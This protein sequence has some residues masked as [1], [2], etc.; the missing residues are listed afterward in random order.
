MSEPQ[1]CPVCK[2][3]A[4]IQSGGDGGSSKVICPRCGKFSI[5]WQ[6]R[7]PAE[8]FS[9]SQTANLSGWIREHQGCAIAVPDMAHLTSLPTP[10]VGEKAERLMLHLA[11]NNSKPGGYI[12]ISDRSAELLGICWC[13]DQEEFLFILLKYLVT[14]RGFLTRGT[15]NYGKS[16]YQITTK[17]WSYLDDLGSKSKDSRQGFIAMWIDDSVN[18]AWKAIDQGIRAAGYNALRI[19]QKQYNNEITDE[20]IAEIRKSRF[21]VADLTDHRN[22]VYFEAGFAKGLGLEVV[23]LCRR[24]ELEKA[25]FDTRQYNFIVWE[26]DKL[27]DLSKALQNRIEA[28]IGRGPLPSAT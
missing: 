16:G 2:T 27:T 17:G 9:A 10:S 19:D 1:P 7:P 22:G 6:A 3:P 15:D 24:D 28:T 20:I 18:E 4:D 25:H 5:G 12:Q 8:Y 11:K 21:L 13:Q 26:A 14:E 23:W